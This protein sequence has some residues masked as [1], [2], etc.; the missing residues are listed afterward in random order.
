MILRLCITSELFYNG[1]KLEVPSSALSTSSTLQ[2]QVPFASTRLPLTS[3]LFRPLSY[4][5]HLFI[6]ST[7]SAASSTRSSY[8]LCLLPSRIASNNFSTLVRQLIIKVPT[9]LQTCG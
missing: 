1:P 7:M 2:S 9:M 8:Q 3:I 5:L 4:Q 6:L